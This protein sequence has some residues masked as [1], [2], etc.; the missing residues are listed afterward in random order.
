MGW[1]RVGV[2]PQP[3]GLA[4]GMGA[5]VTR[6]MPVGLHVFRSMSADVEG[7]ETRIKMTGLGSLS[8]AATAEPRFFQDAVPDTCYL[9]R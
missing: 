8:R 1:T 4:E 9:G 6:G 7:Q 5:H 3:M 2:I